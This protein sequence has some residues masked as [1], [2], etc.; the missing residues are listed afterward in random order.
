MACFAPQAIADECTP[1][2]QAE[3]FKVS[4]PG[5]LHI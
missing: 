4:T 5:C 3:S 1:E 2:E